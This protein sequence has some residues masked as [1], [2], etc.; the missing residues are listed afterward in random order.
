MQLVLPFPPPL[1]IFIST[2]H[3]KGLSHPSL[4]AILSIGCY[5]S[6]GDVTQTLNLEWSASTVITS[7]ITLELLGVFIRSYNREWE[8]QDTPNW[9]VGVKGIPVVKNSPTSSCW[10]VP[11][12]TVKIVTLLTCCSL[13]TRG[14]NVLMVALACN[15]EGTC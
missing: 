10:S 1:F 6:L 15:V 12:A 5:G 11:I 13:V 8:D 4:S 9:L 3:F 14:H 7:M 2:V